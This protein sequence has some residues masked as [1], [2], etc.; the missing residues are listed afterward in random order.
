MRLGIVRLIPS[1]VCS[2]LIESVNKEL[3]AKAALAKTGPSESLA[4]SVSEALQ[5]A[6]DV[7]AEHNQM[8]SESSGLFAALAE[9]QEYNADLQ[10]DLEAARAELGAR[11]EPPGLAAVMAALGMPAPSDN[12]QNQ[13][14]SSNPASTW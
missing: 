4:Q 10:A 12:P 11:P 1:G 7:A 14:T 9:L 2:A 3:G 8:R 13:V 6:A 5:L